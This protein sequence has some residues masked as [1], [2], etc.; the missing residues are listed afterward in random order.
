MGNTLVGVTLFPLSPL[1]KGSGASSGG[2]TTPKKEA[3]SSHSFYQKD[4]SARIV[5]DECI[6]EHAHEVGAIGCDS[7]LPLRES[8]RVRV[9]VYWRVT[10]YNFFESD[11]YNYILEKPL[12][13]LYTRYTPDRNLSRE[14]FDRDLAKQASDGTLAREA[15]DVAL[16]GEPYDVALAR[17]AYDVTLAIEAY[18]VALAR[19]APIER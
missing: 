3:R 17:E 10:S 12:I 1:S 7:K 8:H 16:A 9:G 5:L 11:S 6:T 13:E 14:T 18:D 4:G 19:E 2:R 15:Y